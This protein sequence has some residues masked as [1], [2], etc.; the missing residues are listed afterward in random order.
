L[1]DRGILACEL[2]EL[3]FP[4]GV[5]VDRELLPEKFLKGSE[6]RRRA[7]RELEKLR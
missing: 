5:A 6:G 3:G 1:C 7:H 4:E 2:D